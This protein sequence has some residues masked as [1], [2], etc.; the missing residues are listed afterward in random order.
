MTKN[1]KK[2]NRKLAEARENLEFW[3]EKYVFT[4]RNEIWQ[5]M[6]RSR[7]YKDNMKYILSNIEEAKE[8][9]VKWERIAR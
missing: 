1:I 9:I 3:R 2:A 6:T 4:M 8:D 7:L 5:S